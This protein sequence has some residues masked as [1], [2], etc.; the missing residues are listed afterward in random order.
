VL[1]WLGDEAA[2]AAPDARVDAAYAIEE[3]DF[4]ADAPSDLD[5]D[6]MAA[7]A[8]WDEP[9]EPTLA[10]GDYARIAAELAEG[11]EPRGSTLDRHGL[12]EDGWALEERAWLD[13]MASAAMNGDASPTV[14][15]GDRFVAEQDALA[16]PEEAK[17]TLEDYAALR[18]AM[19]KTGD[20]PALLARRSLTLPEWMRLDRRWTRRAADDP[21]VAARLD[22]ALAAA[23]AAAG[24]VDEEAKA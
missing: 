17:T 15:Y 14:E 20:P 19:E 2:G 23:R 21:E 22:R 18:A 8:A 16:R 1:L 9:V 13:R 10:V 3:R 5:E 6:A 4:V 7:Y 11:K 24:D 12:D